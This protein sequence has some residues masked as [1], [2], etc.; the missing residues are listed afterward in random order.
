MTIQLPK[1]SSCQ[2]AVMVQTTGRIRRQHGE[3]TAYGEEGP[4]IGQK[5]TSSGENT[6]PGGDMFSLQLTDAGVAKG[7]LSD[8]KLVTSPARPTSSSQ[9]VNSSASARLVRTH[10]SA[11]LFFTSCT[12]LTALYIAPT[13]HPYYYNNVTRQSTYVRPV[14]PTQLRSTKQEKP[15]FKAHIPTTDWLRVKTT[16]GNVFYSHKV[17]RE[18]VWIVPDEIKEALEQLEQ[19]ER[20]KEELSKTKKERG[21]ENGAPAKRK[22]E[23]P[24]SVDEVVITKKS[25]TDADLSDEEDEED[26]SDEDEDEEWQLEAAEQ[27]AKEAEELKRKGDE[28]RRIEEMEAEQ[29]SR[30]KDQE[31]ENNQRT[32]S[33]QHGPARVDLSIEE[34]KALFKV[35]VPFLCIH[36]LS[37]RGTD[38]SKGEGYKSSSA[39]G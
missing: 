37:N 17:R 16:E 19:D 25:R 13:G 28:Q 12:F 15:L 1:D 18:S 10:R 8:G 14:L 35:S 33:G 3:Y 2:S 11:F 38:T 31:I 22:A 5:P 26:T 34:A 21:I 23:D 39:M 32:Q 6:R 20:H 27:L 30:K 29:D 36:V 4:L 24:I 9:D 7:R